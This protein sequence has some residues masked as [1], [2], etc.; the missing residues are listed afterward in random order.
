LLRI[1]VVIR[2]EIDD[3]RMTCGA[4]ILLNGFINVVEM[5]AD[6]CENTEASRAIANRTF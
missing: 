1:L 6:W 5:V 3:L 2:A 4:S